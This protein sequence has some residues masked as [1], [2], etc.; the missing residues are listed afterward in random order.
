MRLC[1]IANPKSIHVQRWLEY[2]VAKEY[3]VHLLTFNSP[4]PPLPGVKTYQ[5]LP[6]FLKNLNVGRGW[7]SMFFFFR[8]RRLVDEIHPDILHAHVL[9]VNS[10]LAT[11][12]GYHPRALTMW[13]SDVFRAHRNLTTIVGRQLTVRALKSADLITAV[14]E[15]LFHM[16]QKRIFQEISGQIIRIGVDLKTFFPAEDAPVLRKQL[17]IEKHQPVVLSPRT[18]APIYNI[19]NIIEAVPAVLEQNPETIFIFKDS[20]VSVDAY[21]RKIRHILSDPQIKHAIRI[22]G[23]VPYNQMIS[24]YHLADVVVSV[25]LSDALPVTVLEAMAC[26]VPLVVSD[27][28]QLRHVFVNNK[29]VL[30]ILPQHPDEIATAI[31]RLITDL[32]LRSTL[33][34]NNLELVKQIGDFSAEMNKMDQLYQSLISM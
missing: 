1:Y 28:A 6:S 11:L 33:I 34:K 5:I 27:L 7:L 24:Y 18:F 29:N 10:W 16:A 3:E 32:P 4:I 20:K 8:V 30:S 31:S 26:G 23:R 12:S 2:F 9:S 15:P 22:V 25:P 17:C 19:R 14:S 13:G 21:G